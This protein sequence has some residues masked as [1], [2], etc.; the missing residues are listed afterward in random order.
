MDNSEVNGA[1]PFAVPKIIE[2]QRMEKSIKINLKDA[3]FDVEIHNISLN[4][5]KDL[6]TLPEDIAENLKSLLL[7][8]GVDRELAEEGVN[9]LLQGKNDIQYILKG[10]LGG[11]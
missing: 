9:L 3:S 8:L 7:L 5:I 1:N 2:F 10:C 11:R 6:S 4:H